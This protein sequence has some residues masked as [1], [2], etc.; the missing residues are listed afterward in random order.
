MATGTLLYAQS[1]GVTAVIA[2]AAVL[3]TS[4]KA[5]TVQEE[6][7]IP[8]DRVGAEVGT[9]LWVVLLGGGLELAAGLTVRSWPPAPG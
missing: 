1:G 8:A 3:D 5:E 2:V 6:F 7:A 4:G 9:G